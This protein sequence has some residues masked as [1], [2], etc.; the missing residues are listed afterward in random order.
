VRL[1]ANFKA[2]AKQLMPPLIANWAGRRL[3]NG[4]VWSG[5][6]DSWHAA[7][8]AS[9]G[10]DSQ[11][12]L[13]RVKRATL[14]VKEG[15]AAYERDSVLFDEVQYSWPLLAGL[16]WV[17]ARHRGA[18]D[19]VDFG[20][21]LGSSF[22]QNRRFLQSL[23]RVRWNVVEQ[24]HFVDCGRQSFETEQLRFYQS[25]DDCFSAGCTP[26]VL[27]LSGVLQY[28]EDP[29]ALLDSV[30]GRFGFIL[31][32]LTLVHEGRNDRLTV[33]TVPSSIYPASY[34]CWAL[35]QE[36][37]LSQLQGDFA[38]VTTFDSHIGQ[39]VRIGRLRAR[40]RGL[41]GSREGAPGS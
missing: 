24:P 9:S 7:K 12:V 40:Y 16:M 30:R 34:P 8:A 10:Y 17:A 14:A 20:G 4:I 6:Y 38:V 39:D 11:V 36:R 27:V 21:A 5:D 28:L 13:D 31:I 19:V 33:Q 35:S 26:Q 32:D 18:L 1:G 23:D 25:I 22:H 3:S 37:L 15:R 29:H 2:A 41:I